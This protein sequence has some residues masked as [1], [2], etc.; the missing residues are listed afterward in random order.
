MRSAATAGSSTR[1]STAS[2]ISARRRLSVPTRRDTSSYSSSC[3]RPEIV[4]SWLWNSWV[5]ARSVLVIDSRAL[6]SLWSASS[7]VR[8]RRVVTLATRRPRSSTGLRFTTSTRSPSTTTWS[9]ISAS[10]ASRS[11][12]AGS[13]SRSSTRRPSMSPPRPISSCA[14]SLIT[15]TVPSSATAKTPSRIECS[16]ASRW[17][18]SAAM[19]AGSRPRVRRRMRRESRNEPAAPRPS[20]RPAK[21]IRSGS[22][23]RARS[24][25]VG[26]SSAT[27]A[28]PMSSP[29]RL[30]IGVCAAI[31]GVP[32]SSTSPVHGRSCCTVLSAR[33][34]LRSRPPKSLLTSTTPA[35]SVR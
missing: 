28:I 33:S 18:A 24:P 20:P 19:A 11:R 6:S 30:M 5:C 12:T 1:A 35:G 26:Y 22:T 27:I 17:S 29:R 32:K 3:T 25:H 2:E 21:V 23:L 4:C 7:S 31:E 13:R 16:S 34:M 9:R 15:V 10:S 14:L 8:S